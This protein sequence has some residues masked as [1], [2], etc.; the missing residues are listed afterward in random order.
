MDGVAG[1][2]LGTFFGG[3][4]S[5][6]GSFLQRSWDKEKWLLEH[7]ITNCTECIDL[8]WRSKPPHPPHYLEKIG[9][10]SEDFNG[11]MQTLQNVPAKMARMILFH[12]H[13]GIDVK[14]LKLARERL[15]EQMDN[16]RAGEDSTKTD[17][18][19]KGVTVK[20]S[21]QLPKAIDEALDAV[22]GYMQ[23]AKRPKPMNVARLI[24]NVRATI[25]GR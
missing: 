13:R 1:T 20:N 6:L 2:L 17:D 10:P 11:R 16:V 14:D 9:W 15:I 12:S 7:E 25:C 8:L 4:I 5:L 3:A 19:G 23:W 24:E 21:H 22:E 18:Q